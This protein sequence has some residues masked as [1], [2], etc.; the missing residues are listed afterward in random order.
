MLTI[1]LDGPSDG[2]YAINF[3]K[4]FS[5]QFNPV[6]IFSLFGQSIAFFFVV[7]VVVVTLIFVVCL[8]LPFPCLPAHKWIALAI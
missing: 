2:L 4:M 6:T 8:L 7:V 5:Y 1:G 3:G